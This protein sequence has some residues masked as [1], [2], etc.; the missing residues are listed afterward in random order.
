M[1][2][3]YS[4]QVEVVRSIGICIAALFVG[5]GVTDAV[6]A[7][8]SPAPRPAASPAVCDY[9]SAHSMQRGATCKEDM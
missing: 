7:A 5:W 2:N 3:E 8:R 4:I 9:V 6:K 1:H